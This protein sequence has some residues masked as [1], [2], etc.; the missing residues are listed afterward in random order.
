M[1]YD[2]QKASVLKRISA[3]I[4]DVI[5]L[6]TMV[7][8]FAWLLSGMLGMDAHLDTMNSAY[9][10]YGDMYQ[11]DL[12]ATERAAELEAQ[13]NEAE[14]AL[15][16]DQE[17]VYAYSM[18]MQM[19]LMIVSLSV[20]FGH[21]VMEVGIPLLF[22]NGQTLGKKCF[23]IG[24]MN[25]EGVKL[26]GVDLFV[27]AI[28]GKYTIETMIPIL[29]IYMIFFNGLGMTGLIL[30]VLILVLQI[31]LMIGTHNNAAIHDVM[32]KT[33]A[34]DLAS[35]MIF[36]TREQM[37]EYKKKAHASMVANQRA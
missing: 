29:L 22:R 30:I 5:M 20:L 23:G 12:R 28:L 1:I 11:V 4:F 24:V 25:I 6:I 10:K 7:V 3:Y 32:A 9:D 36:D 33:V 14:S 16:A 17:F 37:I 18:S 2:L 15:Y 21:L 31:G 26:R 19:S 27:R 34:V 8:L 35:Q 13:Y